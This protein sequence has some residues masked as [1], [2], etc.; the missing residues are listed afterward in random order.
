MNQEVVMPRK[1]LSLRSEGVELSCEVIKL[2]LWK[3]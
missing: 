2:E 3:S 1:E